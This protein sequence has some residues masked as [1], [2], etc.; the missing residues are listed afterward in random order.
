MKESKYFKCQVRE[1][2]VAKRKKRAKDVVSVVRWGDG[3]RSS[4]SRDAF[5]Y[6]IALLLLLAEPLLAMD[7]VIENLKLP[8][9]FEAL[10]LVEPLRF[11]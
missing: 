9:L 6:L 1:Q 4:H 2:K 3:G 10:R 11:L 5:A 8:H 7:E